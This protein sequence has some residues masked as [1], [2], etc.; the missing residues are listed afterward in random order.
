LKKEGKK[1]LQNLQELL[2]DD[3]V[4]LLKEIDIKVIINNGYEQDSFKLIKHY[5]K[6]ETECID[7]GANIGIFTIA[8]ASMTNVSRVLSVEPTKQALEFLKKI[9]C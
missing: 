4:I 3:H 2:V 8:F 7:V 6:N 5:L 1:Y 9:L